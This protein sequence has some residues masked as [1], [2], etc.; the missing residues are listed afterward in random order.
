MS[1]L[2]G[3]DKCD[4]MLD[5]EFRAAIDWIKYNDMRVCSMAL[6]P[7]RLLREVVQVAGKAPCI[8]MT[9]VQNGAMRLTLEHGAFDVGGERIVVFDARALLSIDMMAGEDGRC[10]FQWLE[11]SSMTDFAGALKGEAASIESVSLREYMQFFSRFLLK[12]GNSHISDYVDV[13]IRQNIVEMLKTFLRDQ[14]ARS[15]G[16][17]KARLAN[18]IIEYIKKNIDNHDLGAGRIARQFNISQRKLYKIF[19]ESGLSL[20]DTILHYRLEAARKELAS[21][22]E[23]KIINIAFDSG[24]NDVSTFYRNFKRKYGYSPRSSQ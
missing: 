8:V 9:A 24:F 16:G 12:Y 10:T 3:V 13:S 5:G 1:A 23:K 6:P 19:E 18:D 4:F 20:R 15:D 22:S 11:L 17:N 21:S 2:V 14:T 7:G